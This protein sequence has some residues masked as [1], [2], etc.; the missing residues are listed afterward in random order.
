ME[1]ADYSLAELSV[2]DELDRLVKDG[3]FTPKEASGVYVERLNAF[4]SS[5]FYLR[6]KNSDEIMREK[7][8][9]VAMKDIAVDDKY[10]GITGED[11]MIQGIADCV[12]KE[13]D[14]YVIVDYK[15]DNFKDESDM[16]KYGTQ[17]EFYKA[18]LE[19]VLGQERENGTIEKA[20]IKSCYIYSF[21]LGKGKEF[22]L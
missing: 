12:F 22:V 5:E 14:G 10:S 16:D 20:N 19:I 3:F 9:L 2:K 17:L 6:M 13:D 18:A 15:T 1:L 7:K 11:G 21:R 8:F 4:F